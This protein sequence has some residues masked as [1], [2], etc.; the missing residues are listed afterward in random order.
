M[1]RK[2]LVAWDTPI[3]S[4]K[5]LSYAAGFHTSWHTTAKSNSSCAAFTCAR[6]EAI[7]G[8]TGLG[9]VV[10]ALFMIEAG[11]GH[12]RE[13]L[14]GSLKSTPGTTKCASASIN[15]ANVEQKVSTVSTAHFAHP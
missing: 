3:L 11:R 14:H 2:A 9:D 4:C 12:V 10:I 8:L 13:H 1:T 6:N 15:F 7:S 5:S